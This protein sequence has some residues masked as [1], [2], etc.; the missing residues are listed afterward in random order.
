[1]FYPRQEIKDAMD[2]FLRILP[3]GHRD[4]LREFLRMQYAPHASASPR[5]ELSLAMKYGKKIDR[6]TEAL[7]KIVELSKIKQETLVYWLFKEHAEFETDAT[8]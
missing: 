1:M 8:N 4:V 6:V 5:Q 3:D 7:Q 2:A